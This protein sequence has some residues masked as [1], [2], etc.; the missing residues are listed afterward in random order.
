MVS[1]DGRFVIVFN[2][3]IY[4]FEEL[5]SQLVSED[6]A[7]RFR[8]DSDTEVMLEAFTRWGI[9]QTVRALNGMFAFALWDRRDRRLTLGRDRI[10]EKPLYYGYVGGVFAFASELKA[11][12]MIPGAQ[13]QLDRGSLSLYMRYSCVPGAGSIYQGIQKLPP[14]CLVS[15]SSSDR[16]FDLPK[17]VAYWTA[18]QAALQGL[19]HPF[20][21]SAQEATRAVETLLSDAVLLRMRADVPLGAFLSGGIDSSTIVALMQAQSTRPVKTFTIGFHEDSYDEANW[22][23][24]VARHLGTD[25]CELY[26]TAREAMDVIPR[27]PHM[28]DEPFAD[29]SQIPTFLVSQMTRHAVTVALTGDGGDELF[30]GYTRYT[31]GPEIWNKVGWM[32]PAMRRGLAGLLR[33]VS[34]DQWEGLSPL[35][36][37]VLSRYGAQGSF[38][39]K[40]HKAADVLEL[41]GLD[42]LYQRFVSEWDAPT[43]VVL[44][45]NED[46]SGLW[47]AN[48]GID[49]LSAQQRMML[50][51]L[52]GYLPDDI[53][54]KLDR[55]SM[56][57]SLEGR[58]PFLDHRVVE[59]AWS[60]PVAYKIKGGQGKFVLR[61]ILGRHVPDKLFNRPKMGFGLPIDV[62]LRGPLRDWAEALLD[63]RRLRDE[64]FLNPVAIR[65][66]WSEHQSR[67]RNWH[68]RLWCVL[69][70]QAWLESEK[71]LAV[72]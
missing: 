44:R 19:T 57:V 41:S 5:R 47:G 52:T 40:F 1:R 17:P 53:L 28:Y 7:L 45:G 8:G 2:G 62:W 70:F 16:A 56:A 39:D 18:S 30:G 38:G 29:A 33:R 9:D 63:E 72:R 20:S 42:K 24:D 71:S 23:R 3:E 11:L 13:L 6:P 10:G 58:T 54:V 60:L 50:A 21:G 31:R 32:P 67:R 35:L 65:R 22:A 49:G 66:I 12:R 4:N 26:V 64:G 36:G 15:I 43:D 61:Q 14:G 37:K 25:H 34:P 55:A 59:L 46:Q 68:G 69:M 48:L 27:L 51:D